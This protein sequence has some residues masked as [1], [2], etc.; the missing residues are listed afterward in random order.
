MFV[1]ADGPLSFCQIVRIMIPAED[2]NR[3]FRA[4]FTLQ[5]QDSA[6]LLLNVIG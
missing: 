6:E 3:L 4:T 2:G 5:A 1:P